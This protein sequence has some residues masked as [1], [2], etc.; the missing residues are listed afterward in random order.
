MSAYL[1]FINIVAFVATLVI[2]YLSQTPLLNGIT[3]AEIANR[4]PDSLYFPAN[5]AFSI[6]GLIYSFLLAYLINQAIPSQRNNPLLKRIGWLFVATCVFNAAWVLTFQFSFFPLSMLLML[7]LLGTLLTIY[8]RLDI[9][10]APVSRR[11]KWLIHIPFSIYLGWIT[12][13]T[14]ANATYVLTDIGWDGFGLGN[15]TWALIM[16]I[17]T[18]VVAAFMVWFRRDIAYGLVIVWAV[19]WIYG[20]YNGTEFTLTSTAALV[21]A[22]A[23][24]VLVAVRFFMTLR[25]G[26]AGSSLR[27]TRAAA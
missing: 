10:G 11:D 13:A 6:W 7:A 14:I 1:P 16:L 23:V 3:T 4:F 27:T 9:G 21:V 8:I 19:G 26:P 12:A 22:L 15:E 24:A 2:N 20:R 17:V 5:S 18:G 25:G